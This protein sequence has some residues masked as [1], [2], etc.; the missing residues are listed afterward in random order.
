MLVAVHDEHPGPV[1]AGL[2]GRT[3]G[4]VAAPDHHHI[5]DGTVRHVTPFAG[6]G[7]R[8]L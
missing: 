4:R 8:A 7:T 6:R 1:L 3:H 2:Q 5:P